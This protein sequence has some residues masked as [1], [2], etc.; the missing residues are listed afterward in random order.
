LLSAFS[1]LDSSKEDKIKTFF[2]LSNKYTALIIFPVTLLFI[3]FSKEIIQV[4]YGATYQS[5]ALFLSLYC[6]LY[7]LVALGYLNLAS[8]F[9]GLGDTKATMKISLITFVLVAALS[10]FFT[11]AYSVVGLIIAFLIA[12]TVGISYG[13]F[14]AR[15]KYQVQFDIAVTAKILVV[16][17][18]SVAP[19]V[20]VRL[21][22][23]P[24]Y[25]TL[26]FG[27]CGYLLAYLTL[28]PLTR[29]V[30]LGELKMVNVI[31]QKIRFLKLIGRITVKY[32]MKLC[33]TRML[34]KS[35]LEALL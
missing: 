12:N 30:T 21:V 11:Q 24:V 23:L 5:A 17:L 13:A 4:V 14:F 7:F 31:L 35:K 9:N 19:L 1:K 25:V 29:I 10:P 20:V 16:S 22:V 28:L 18:L 32:E 34:V 27:V 2:K 33:Q 3:V 26:A 15:K 6:L 8:F